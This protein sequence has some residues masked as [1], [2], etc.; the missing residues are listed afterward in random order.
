MKNKITFI[1]LSIVFTSVVNAQK[2]YDGLWT[3]V[4]K[5]EVQNLPK[6]ALKI[7]DTIYT[8]ASS[9]NNNEQII[10]SL[11]YKSKFA[12]ILEE[13]PQLKIINDFKKEINNNTFPTKNILENVL[14]NLYWQYFNQNRYQ[15]YNR[16]KIESKNSV[17]DF[18]KWDLE[19]LFNEIHIH[20]K[21]SLQNDKKLHTL[22]IGAFSE[23]LQLEKDAKVYS[24]TLFDFLAN[25]AL[26]FYKTSETSITKPSYKFEID[27]ANFLKSYKEFSKL[28]I[29]S[30]DSTSLQLNALKIYQK[31]I[32]FHQNKK[33]KSA[34]A[35]IDIDRL[36]FV[37]NNAVFNQKDS[38]FLNTL[39]KTQQIHTN[40]KSVGLYA[41]EVAQSFYLKATIDKE[42]ITK[43]KEALSICNT[44]LKN[45]PKSLGA[46]KCFVLKNKITEQSLSIKTEKYIPIQQKTRVLVTY[47]NIESLYFRAFKISKKELKEFQ[48]IYN[49]TKKITFLKS[50]KKEKEWYKKLTNKQ[51][52][53][54]HT[55]EIF[56]PEFK[57][58]MYLIV[59]SN[60]F[61]LKEK[62]LFG[63]AVLQATNLTLVQ[64]TFNNSYN[65]QIVDRNNGKPIKNANIH[66]QNAP[67]NKTAR[68]NKN[69]CTDRKGFASF[70]TSKYY[71]NVNIE[72]TTKKDTAFFGSQYFYEQ[73]TD[74]NL[75]EE[76]DEIIIKPFIFT[77]RSI[78]RPGQTVY[79]KTIF[80]Q[81]NNHLTKP[82]KNKYI[83]IELLDVNDQVVDDVD[84]Q[85]S[86]FGS[87]SGEFI[88]PNNGLTGLFSI[89]F[90]ESD[91]K[92]VSSKFYDDVAFDFDDDFYISVEEYKR[93]KFKTEFKPITESVQLND[94]VKVNGF[95]KAFSGA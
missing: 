76:E 81:K 15:F 85:L 9:E 66:L 18:R 95:A 57:N 37:K 16:T 79:F 50:L 7:V 63:T 22:D 71:Q 94:S 70:K 5:L 60:K 51:D 91:K 31:L 92:Y 56:T 2:N 35:A 88:I 87:A 55:T 41:F 64:N 73:D 75:N 34:L 27:D 62:Q 43:N 67:K 44:I 82:F 28:K 13:N 86:E 14:A 3:K 1:I 45:Y 48:K 6:S 23:I 11:F 39:Q 89:S 54:S 20:F 58:G 46:K 78:Y 36:K 72:V 49:P 26:V 59:A 90:N 77:D 74:S 47:K 38:L 80:I 53:L 52:Y 61:G 19:T 93:P 32:E 8:K 12:L 83:K 68:I 4:E 10:K 21:A 17:S 25:N 30:K 69:L 84:I 33:N 24:P 42:N 65:F 29:A 40:H